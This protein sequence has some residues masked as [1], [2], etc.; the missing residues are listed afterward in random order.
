MAKNTSRRTPKYRRQN[1][2]HAD[3]AFVDLAGQRQYLGA[4]G[5]P[6]SKEA[7]HRLIAEWLAGGE[8][9]PVDPSDLTVL[10]L[11]DRFWA[12]VEGY[13][14]KPDGTATDE[15]NNFRQAIRP[16]L[17]LYGR[18]NAVE[19]GP[20][21]LK[22]VRQVMIGNGW[23]RTW[24]N[25]SVARL[26]HLFKWATENELLP[27][28]VYHGLQAVSGLKRGRTE[29]HETVPVRPVPDSLVNATL[30]H[31]TRVQ[32]AMVEVQRLT[33]MRP[34]EVCVVRA[35]DLDMTG[36]VWTYQPGDHKTAHRGRSR[37]VFIGPRA[38]ST[39]RPFLTRDLTAY[40]FSPEESEAERRADQH[41]RR[42]TPMSCGNRPGTNRTRRPL[43]QPSERYD[44]R[45]YGR[46]ITYACDKA[47][48]PPEDTK[49]ED[50]KRWR[51][52]HRWAPNQL[53]HSYATHVRREHG[54]EAAQVLLGHA[55]AD[56]T[57]AY[58]ERD[59][60]KAVSVA[61]KIG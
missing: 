47:F 33:G 46:A 21:A 34:G 54:L 32:R 37:T 43:K 61:A 4:Y 17:K 3:R 58:A 52:E 20:L 22:C 55:M 60:A 16:L 13:Y 5:S 38:Q 23:S 28:I 15:V 26:K 36:N 18:T 29:A 35:R 11:V 30:P 49:G 24:I 48:P 39:L 45:S 2:K 8:Q 19:F 25:K 31:M 12:H 7:Y 51:R 10:E 41:R 50:L 40:L 14:R 59:V 53:R 27:P 44:T 6:E 42:K 57:Q 56:V 9:T 1:G